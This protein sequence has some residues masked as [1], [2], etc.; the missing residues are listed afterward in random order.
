MYN[1]RFKGSFK[2]VPLYVYKPCSIRQQT[3]G[4]ISRIYYNILFTPTDLPSTEY[5]W[6]SSRTQT[7]YKTI[8]PH[9]SLSYPEYL[10]LIQDKQE[11]QRVVWTR[12][13][14]LRSNR[15]ERLSEQKKHYLALHQELNP[16]TT[17]VESSH[18]P[19][20]CDREFLMRSSNR[21]GNQ[22]P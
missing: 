10:S 6:S 21:L 4:S 18:D 13:W 16:R 19:L 8:A 15:A 11:Q 20:Y 3:L 14:G 17:Q 22:R 2:A 12:L 9:W 7:C 1:T 5:L